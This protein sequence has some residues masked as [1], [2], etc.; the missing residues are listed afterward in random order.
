MCQCL[1]GSDRG[2]QVGEKADC[3]VP[4]FCDGFP[5]AGEKPA[6]LLC[7]PSQ[8]L[9][10]GDR[11]PNI[12]EEAGHCIP[13]FFD[14][15]PGSREETADRFRNSGQAFVPCDGRPYIGEKAG[16]LASVAHTEEYIKAHQPETETETQANDA[17][18][19]EH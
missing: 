18:E 8:A 11:R 9:V 1:I 19:Q 2:P 4:G 10:A 17:Q 3:S 6:D 16:D 7:D 12:S 13:D 14:R 15:I 5:C